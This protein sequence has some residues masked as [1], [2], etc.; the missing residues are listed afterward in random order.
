MKQ[1]VVLL[2]FLMTTSVAIAQEHKDS[3][4]CKVMNELVFDIEVSGGTRYKGLQQFN[5]AIDLGYRFFNRIYPY[6]RYEISLM[7]YKHDGHKEY[8]NTYNIGGGIGVV[9]TELKDDGDNDRIEFTTNVT[10]SVGG[11]DYKNTSWYLGFRFR[12]SKDSFVALG[13]RHMHSRDTMWPDYR[14]FVVSFGF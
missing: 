3:S 5:G 4:C 13:F 12:S 2:V 6:F 7:L 11:H 8:G 10:T 9:L 14:A 1:I